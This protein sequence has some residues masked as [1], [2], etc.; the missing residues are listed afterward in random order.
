MYI[1]YVHKTRQIYEKT[2]RFGFVEF[3]SS[4]DECFS[5]T[6]VGEHIGRQANY[7]ITKLLH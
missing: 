2:V 3:L 5:L 4:Y 1:V 6:A 7:E